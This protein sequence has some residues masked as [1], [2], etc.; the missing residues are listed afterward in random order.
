MLRHAAPNL[1]RQRAILAIPAL[2]L[3]AAVS[4]G[5]A[6]AQQSE[7]DTGAEPLSAESRNEASVAIAE[8]AQDALLLRRLLEGRQLLFFGRLE[9]ELA[10][11]DIPD[12]ADENGLA[13]RRFRVGLAGLNPWFSNIS[14]KLE[15][16]LSEGS[17]SLSST[18]LSVDFAR[19]GSLT[20]GNQDGSQSL[21]AST[22][23]LSQL[24]MEA[25]LPIEAFGLDQRVGISFDRF[26]SRSG[27]HLL[28]FG[29]DLDSDAKH[30]GVAA[31]AYFNPQ[32]SRTGILHFGVSAVRE[33]IDDATRLHAR[34][35][36][37]V[38]DIRLVDTGVYDDVKSTRRLGVE[39]AG[40]TGSFSTRFEA[41]LN[42]WRRLDGSRNRFAG[43]YL[44]GGYFITGQ[45]FRYRDGKFVRPALTG[46]QAAWELAYRLSWLD[47]NDG[48]VQGGEERNAGVALNYY[49]RPYA[50][51][52]A[53]L[54][55]V[56]SDRLG[57]DGWLVQARL[58]LNW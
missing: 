24:F 41:L 11:Y 43:A 20:I 7:P 2:L 50:R 22:G 45:P 9:G 23:S 15:L 29:Q 35:E 58:Q 25:P 33:D 40:A 55:Q 56:N 57:G 54:V 8:N 39:A 17:S 49:P 10:L 12:L 27:M 6:A 3:A 48:D 36:S 42:E 14:Y 13:L 38:S 34:P 21:A 26:G 46:A 47:L 37:H 28:I 5:N 44:E 52:Q 19:K 16:D 18:Y 4:L 31:R 32:R 51:V 53:N 1:R 30:Q